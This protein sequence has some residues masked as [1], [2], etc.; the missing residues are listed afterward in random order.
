MT[1][2][3]ECA[4]FNMRENREMAKLGFGKCS[5]GNKHLYL[6]PNYPRECE[7]FQKSESE[8]TESRIKFFK[9]MGLTNGTRIAK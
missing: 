3:L 2:C 9:K 1:N 4:K 6:S 8:V 7:K 5:A